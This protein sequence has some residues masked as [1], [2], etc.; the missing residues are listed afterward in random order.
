MRRKKESDAAGPCSAT[1]LSTL[2]LPSLYYRSLERACHALVSV[3][4]LSSG[5]LEQTNRSHSWQASMPPGGFIDAAGSRTVSF[6]SIYNGVSF[7]SKAASSYSQSLGP[8]KRRLTRNGP[9]TQMTERH[10]FQ[11]QKFLQ[12]L[13][14]KTRGL[15]GALTLVH[16]MDLIQGVFFIAMGCCKY[17]KSIPL[18]RTKQVRMGY[19]V[20]HTASWRLLLN[21]HLLKLL[22]T[23]PKL[24]HHTQQYVTILLKDQKNRKKMEARTNSRF[25]HMFLCTVLHWGSAAQIFFATIPLSKKQTL[26]LLP[27]SVVL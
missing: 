13:I 7:M 24:L 15:G 10:H 23:S 4:L 14:A 19:F 2:T 12:L 22:H 27:C 5:S 3:P 26:G 18:S 21:A 25:C 8:Y 17:I 6:K 11:T 20:F 16:I 1:S 9:T